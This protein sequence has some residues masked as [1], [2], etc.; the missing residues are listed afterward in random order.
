[1][2]KIDIEK[3]SISPET[4]I[5][6]AMKKIDIGEIGAAFIVEKNG[7]LKNLI[8][9]GDIRRAL[10]KGYGLESLVSV[11]PTK[12]ACVVKKNTPS[13]ELS[14]KFNDKIRIIPVVDD[15]NRVIDVH[16]RDKRAYIPV[17]NPFFDENEIELLNECILTG[18]VS[19]GGP[20]VSKFEKLVA[21]YVGTKYAISCSSGTS[22]LHLALLANDIGPGDEVI[23]PTLTFIATA[24]A[25]TY[26]GA[27]PVFVDS[28]INTWNID[29]KLI[30]KS[31][32]K[33]TKAI[34]PVHLYGLPADMDEINKI[35]NEFDLKVI[36]DASEAQG[37]RYKNKMVGSLGDIAVFSFFG[38]K[39][40]TTGEGGMV[41]TNNQNLAERCQILR[42][43][44]MSK[45]RRYWHTV[46]GYNYRMTNMQAAIGVAQM[47][48][49]EKIIKRKK[50][51]VDEYKNFLGSTKGITFPPE[52]EFSENV[53]WLLTI[54][55]DEKFLGQ[56]VIDLMKKLRDHNVDTRRI[57]PPV[58]TQPIYDEGKKLPISEKIH[59]MGLTL[60][61]SY[62]L[63]SEQI[64]NICHL[65]LK[66]TK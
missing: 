36:E 55:I 59:L 46:I 49:I 31:I 13:I 51:I 62:E 4:T 66:Y 26:T 14:K 22:G 52:N 53:F 12:D 60:P 30:K 42:D 5:R 33:K 35:A 34:I 63:K 57:F 40:I 65:L 39:M 41:L 10:L 19:S 9:D 29:P 6:Q 11:I 3:I 28:D 24:N 1:M 32:T 2:K 23:V 64:K 8:T 45:E 44:G 56:K 54:L 7:I 21:E 18:W 17:A 58:H 20:F 25:V 50:E 27:K 43:H 38:N 16:Y 61:S 48:K 37:A 15:M 47:G